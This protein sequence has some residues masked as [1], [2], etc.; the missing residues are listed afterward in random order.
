MEQIT[1]EGNHR[2]KPIITPLVLLAV[3]AVVECASETFA[4]QELA[5]TELML[6]QIGANRQAIVMEN[7]NLTA[8][9]C[10]LFWALH[11]QLQNERA[12][13]QPVPIAAGQS[14]A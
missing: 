3:A 13:S 10:E 9:E 6:E 8:E 2:I 5:A 4:E 11:Q 7:R 1:D 14:L 12:V